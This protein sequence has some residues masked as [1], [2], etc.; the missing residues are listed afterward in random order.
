MKPHYK[1]LYTTQNLTYGTLL[2]H[3]RPVY[4]KLFNEGLKK[5]DRYRFSLH[6]LRHTVASNLAIQ[7]VSLLKIKQILNHKSIQSTLIYS[8][9]QNKDTFNDIDSLYT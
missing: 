9:L 5:H 2:Y 3:M 6:N 8:K 1:V 4:D 7:G